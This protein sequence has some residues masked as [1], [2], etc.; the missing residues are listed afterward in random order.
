M[1]YKQL[2]LLTEHGPDFLEKSHDILDSLIDLTA[3]ALSVMTE[4]EWNEC[5][6][7]MQKFSNALLDANRLVGKRME[8]YGLL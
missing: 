2:E 3:D 7:A 6:E 1:T 8:D 5:R 4:K